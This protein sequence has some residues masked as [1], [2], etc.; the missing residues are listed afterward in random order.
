[1]NWLKKL[2]S[3]VV[4]KL[5]K[6]PPSNDYSELQIKED[7]ALLLERM[8]PSETPFYEKGIEPV[9]LYEWRTDE[10]KKIKD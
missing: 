5:R 6:T 2:Y 9:S 1:M 4:S 7:L 3:Y 8:N 10:L